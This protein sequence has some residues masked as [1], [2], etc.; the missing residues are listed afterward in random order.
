MRRALEVQERSSFAGRRRDRIGRAD[1]HRART[2]E[3]GKANNRDVTARS[4]CASRASNAVRATEGGAPQACDHRP[5]AARGIW[6]DDSRFRR[7]SVAGVALLSA[8]SGNCWGVG[9]FCSNHRAVL[10]IPSA[11]GI[12]TGLAQRRTGA[13]YD[14]SGSTTRVHHVGVRVRHRP[15]S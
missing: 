15:L 9:R 6:I 2:P 7:R 10:A 8:G 1:L 4:S 12:G 13:A 5:W 11:D 3:T 14:E